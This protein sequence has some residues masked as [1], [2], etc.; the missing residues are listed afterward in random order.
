MW[1]WRRNSLRRR[2]DVIEVWLVLAAW[3]FAMAGGLLVGVTA[4]GAVERNLDRQGRERHA[5][6]AVLTEGTA[7]RTAVPAVD[8]N[9]VWVT[10]RWAAPDG[11]PRTGQTK[12]S[13]GT[14]KGAQVTVWTDRQGR[15]ASRPPSPSQA[16]SEGVWVGA[17]AAL[18]VGAAAIGSAQCVRGRLERRRMEAWAEEWRRFDTH[19]GRMAG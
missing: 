1:R 7:G 2:S 13:P 10:V 19:R 8:D 5:V 15:L 11:S 12:V 3:V 9:Q 16:Q 6:A 14:A 18:A 4:A 17:L